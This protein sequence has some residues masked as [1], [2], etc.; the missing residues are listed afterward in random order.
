M[1]SV[2]RTHAEERVLLLAPTRKDG[3][4]SRTIL[5]EAGVQADT[6]PDMPSLCS[7]LEQ[8]AGVLLLTDQTI[9]W[10]ES[11][12]LAEALRRQPPW[13]ELPILLLAGDG[14]DSPAAVWAMERL[15]N[16]TVL[17]RPVRLSTLVSAL[18]SALKA[19]RR[20]YELR[21][22]LDAR[23][24]LEQA[25]RFLAD[26]SAAL[27]SP[28][29]WRR[30]L[31]EIATL[32]VPRFA[33][34]C[35]VEVCEADDRLQR[36]TAVHRDPDRARLAE[37]LGRRYPPDPQRSH[38]LRQVLDS[39]RPALVEEVTDELLMRLARDDEQLRLL[40]ELRLKSYL[41]VPLP[42]GG[43]MRAVLTFATAE[44]GWR[45]TPADLSLAEE[46]ERRVAN[47]IETAQLNAE[48]R[49]TNR[50]KDEFLA[51]LAH[52]LRNPL[53]PISNALHLLRRGGS[54]REAE[55]QEMLERQVAQLVRLVDDLLEISRISGGRIELRKERVNLAAVVRSAL[56]TSGPLLEAGRHE[57]DI[58]LPA[59]PL[60]LDADPIR[61]AQ[62]I[63]NL[64]NNAAKYTEEGGKVWLRVGREDGE[65][66]LSVRDTGLGIPG[67]M[68][69]RVFDMFAQVDQTLKRSQGGLGVGLTL[70]RNLVELHGGRIEAHSE[71]P[72]RGSEFTV[73]LPLAADA[74]TTVANGSAGAP[75]PDGDLRRRPILVVDDN[76]DAADSLGQVLQLLG[77]DVRIVYDGPSA[78]EALNEWRPDV[79]LLDIGMPGMDGH[80]LARQ[81][82]A[83]PALE[84]V[85]LIALTG[86]GQ[87]EDRRRSREAGFD[88]HLVK[89]V[90]IDAL[91]SLLFSL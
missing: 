52:E 17:E 73:R 59:E 74:D 68:L 2:P 67:E 6:A 49:E 64:L 75:R 1:D 30:A 71:G 24:R 35:F 42:A 7:A 43:R 84:G 83:A 66:V 27:G 70:A 37:E 46:L 56:Q 29:D 69:P 91:Q 41:C 88:H 38:V 78:L 18:R 25:L 53:A 82:R 44:S 28:S 80:D 55:L 26:A 57:V 62:V 87:E 50:R 21:D 32:A 72:G 39:G 15:G 5:H 40:R 13:S 79:I 20:Q 47:G 8:G 3:Q 34:L 22:R 58:D 76:R 11:G 85:V 16:V 89:P 81:V 10:D 86:W 33:D 31:R 90:D 12:A 23:R 9:E 51:T 48:I 77:G 36:L 4:L 60:L 61:L 14:A 19:R 63:A 45:Y 65:A 54:G